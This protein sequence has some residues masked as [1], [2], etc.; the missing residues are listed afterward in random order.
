[1][2]ARGLFRLTPAELSARWW[3]IERE[4]E[5]ARETGED[6]ITTDAVEGP[7]EQERIV[8]ILGL[9]PGELRPERWE[10]VRVEG[11]ERSVRLEVI[12]WMNLHA[13]H[14]RWND[15]RAMPDG[16]Q[17][18]SLRCVMAS[19]GRDRAMAELLAI[20]GPWLQTGK[21]EVDV[22]LHR[23]VPAERLYPNAW[24]APKGNR[25]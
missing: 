17:L 25:R 16:S 8:R 11:S 24:P 3:A 1:M 20:V 10:L 9:F 15:E 14:A 22:V 13:D 4:L 19:A 21:V 2:S 5:N 7:R 18:W 12:R 6:P 23:L